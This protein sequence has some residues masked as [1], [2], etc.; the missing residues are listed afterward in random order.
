MTDGSHVVVQVEDVIA[1]ALT[2]HEG[3][4]Y[5]SPP[6][7]RERALALVRVLLGYTDQPVNGCERWTCPVAGGRRTVWLDHSAGSSQPATITNMAEGNVKVT[8]TVLGIAG[9]YVVA[10]TRPDGALVLEPEREKLSALE[11]ETAGKVFRDEE[12]IER[13]ERVAETEDD[14]GPH[15][16]PRID[17]LEREH[18]PRV[19]GAEFS[20]SWG[21]L[22][23]DGE[24]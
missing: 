8:L 10:E 18:G 3:S 20:G 24:G 22:P 11:A 19:S 14:I 23:S 7:P 16:G 9:L 15:V 13:L 21:Q 6:Q 5:Q 2:G 4:R 12:L 17:E 1:V